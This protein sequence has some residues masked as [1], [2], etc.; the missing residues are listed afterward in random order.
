M[1]FICILEGILS[2]S[3]KVHCCNCSRK[4][5]CDVHTV[6]ERVSLDLN[7]P[8]LLHD[9]KQFM[10]EDFTKTWMTEEMAPW[11]KCLLLKYEDLNVD[12]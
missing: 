3:S 8:W 1:L 7:N 4:C 11:V 10:P 12:H 5:L 2:T 9:S 6:V